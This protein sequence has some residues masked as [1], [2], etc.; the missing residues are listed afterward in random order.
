[1]YQSAA[2]PLTLRDLAKA[3]GLLRLNKA[4]G[5]GHEDMAKI[6]VMSDKYLK[7]D[8]DLAGLN[9]GLSSSGD[10]YDITKNRVAV[11]SANA[12]ILA[13]EIGHAKDLQ[14]SSSFYKNI[15]LKG[16]KKLNSIL[17][18]SVV[19]LGGVISAIGIP[20]K[21][22]DLAFKSLIGLSALS[23]VPNLMSEAAASSSAIGK[24]G[25]KSGT[26]FAM[27]PGGISHLTKDLA[28]AYQYAVMNAVRKNMD[29]RAL[30]PF[31]MAGAPKPLPPEHRPS[32]PQE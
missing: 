16:S 29:W 30:A 5:G 13:H 18:K 28:P 19:P 8:P 14:N 31:D 23:S 26:L 10:F 1:M 17:S 11:S 27:L 9:I 3:Q 7:D 22:K 15:L 12:D 6:M 21:N 4:L 24:S 2:T 25:D 20:E 32:I